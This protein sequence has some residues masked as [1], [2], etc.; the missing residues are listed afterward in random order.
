M[1]FSYLHFKHPNI[2]CTSDEYSRLGFFCLSPPKRP[3]WKSQFDPSTL[4]TWRHENPGSVVILWIPWKMH[5]ITTEFWWNPD[6]MSP[7]QNSDEKSVGNPSRFRQFR[8]DSVAIPSHFL[9]SQC[10][11]A[12]LTFS[13]RD[14]LGMIDWRKKF[15]RESSLELRKM[16]GC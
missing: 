10:A 1:Q 14:I 15:N 7:W 5:G 8:C 2:L 9:C 6:G 12:E 11:R 13:S 3:R 4:G 16:W